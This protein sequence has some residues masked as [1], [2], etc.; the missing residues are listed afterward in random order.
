M[1]TEQQ[2]LADVASG[3]ADWQRWGTYVSDCRAYRWNEDGIAGREGVL[4]LLDNTPTHLY[5]R[6]LYR[7]PQVEFPY[8]DL[9]TETGRRGA[10]EPGYEL[11]DAVGD[12]FEAG[13]YFDVFVEYAKAGVEDIACRI[14]VINKGR[15]AKAAAHLYARVGAGESLTVQIR[16]SP[17][18][19]P[20]PFAHFDALFA[21]RIREADELYATFQASTLTDDERLVQRQAFAGLL[22]SKQFYHYD[23]HL[24]L[25]GDPAQPPPPAERWHGRNRDWA[26][27]FGNA[28]IILM[29]DKWEYLWYAVDPPVIAWAVW[30]IDQLDPAAWHGRCRVPQSDVRPRASARWVSVFRTGSRGWRARVRHSRRKRWRDGSNAGRCARLLRSD[31]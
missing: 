15:E 26:L 12:A 21:R 22:W 20:R 10:D 29:P 2:R 27:H 9:V 11:I 3:R 25:A 18:E 4:L 1:T 31:R 17:E 30:Q 14:R 7:C 24:W 16:L 19:K 23:V 5:A 6:M 13:R 28:G 8:A